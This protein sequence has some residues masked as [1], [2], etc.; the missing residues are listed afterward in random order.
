[1]QKIKPDFC[2]T[3]QNGLAYR[4][5][6]CLRLSLSFKLSAQ[7]IEVVYKRQHSQA[8]N[9]QQKIEERMTKHFL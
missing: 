2:D 5:N 9:C 7:L 3:L 4:A 8:A 6:S 1:M